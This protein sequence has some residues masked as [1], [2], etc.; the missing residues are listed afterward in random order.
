MVNYTAPDDSFYNQFKNAG[1]KVIPFGLGSSYSMQEFLTM[2]GGD[3][4]AVVE[5]SFDGL[6]NVI[7]KFKT[8]A[9]QYERECI[10][11]CTGT[12]KTGTAGTHVVFKNQLQYAK[13]TV[14]SDK[15][16][17]VY[18][19]TKNKNPN[20]ANSFEFSDTGT[21]IELYKSYNNQNIG[22]KPD[23]HFSMFPCD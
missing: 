22:I 11:T 7:N 13:Y 9:C 18:G 21:E 16:V 2:T 23:M 6:D 12:H 3:R 4:S 15:C 8:T 20:H 1:V 5:A 10:G 14:K 19:S 17:V